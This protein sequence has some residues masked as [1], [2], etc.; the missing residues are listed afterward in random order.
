M[1]MNAND[2]AVLKNFTAINEGLVVRAGEPIYTKRVG[3]QVVAKWNVGESMFPVDFALHDLSLFLQTMSL[4]DSPE[5][6]FKDDF[7]RLADDRSV[8]R[9]YYS[10]EDV[11]NHP[12]DQEIRKIESMGDG[13]EV[14]F[15]LTKEDFHKIQKASQVMRLPYVKFV[16]D[17]EKVVARVFTNGTGTNSDYTI[18]IDT[19]STSEFEAVVNVEL[20]TI[21]PFDYTVKVGDNFILMENEEHGLSYWIALMEE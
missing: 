8:V 11:V 18:T 17:G 13:L 5:I 7:V 9:Y 16:G 3:N 19:N 20:M 14:D 10:S 2:I 4:F 12:T 6:E 21:L 15:F 1:N